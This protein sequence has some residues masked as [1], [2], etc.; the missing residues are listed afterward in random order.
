MKVATLLDLIDQGSLALPEFQRGFVWNRDQVRGLMLSLY[1]RRPIGSL[2]VWI[3]KS[4]GARTRGDGFSP[5]GMISLLLDGQQRLTSLYGVMR[6]RPPRFFDGHASTFIGLHFHIEEE[7]FEYYAPVKMKDNP[8]W[9]NVTSVL[10]P[11]GLGPALQRVLTD[12]RLASKSA[13]YIARLNAINN[14]KDVELHVEQVTGEDKTIDVVVDIF[15]QV[16]SGGTK[17]SKGDLALAKVCAEWPEARQEMKERLARWRRAGFNFKLELLLRCITTITTGQAMF[18]ALSEATAARVRQGLM[19]AEKAV[20]QSLNLIASRLGLD[21]DRVFGSRYS[22][23]LL[24]RYVVMNGG[25]LP[26]GKDRDRLLY[27]Y[28]HTFLWGRYAGSTES[29]LNQDLEAIKSNDGAIERLL[30][31]LRRNRGD[32]RIQTEDFRGWSRGARFYPLLYMLTRV[33]R[34]K[35]FESELELS[36][37]LLG[38]SNSLELHHVFPRAQLYKAGYK[39]SEVNALANFTFLTKETN[40]LISDELPE[41]YLARYAGRSKGLVESH[42][43]PMDRDLWKVGNYRAFLEERRKLLAKAANNFLD[44]LSGGTVPETQQPAIPVLE[45]RI[46][47]EIEEESLL[48]EINEW[49]MSR[50]LAEGEYDIE[51]LEPESQEIVAV[52]DL[53]WPNGLQEGLSQPV[54]LLLNEDKETEE[55]VNQAGYRFF[56]TVDAFRRY[57]DREVAA[58]GAT[59][60]K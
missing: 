47:A 43:I 24:A 49:V 33:W 20:H 9:V 60:A 34:A 28:V 12:S 46:E 35:D 2:L 26:G 13:V 50:G 53:G 30:D 40:Q 1:R 4:E 54:A 15:N 32:L 58:S 59:A 21:H 27:W 41:M 31:N 48:R 17:L 25:K 29:V 37:H 52:I 6:G 39:K 3:T 56:R 16:N 10:Q 5:P 23:P 51:V 22:L 11:D 38:Q 18:S 36:Q 42:W 44:Q 8:L 19:D 14:I 7:A 55:A 45:R 57:V